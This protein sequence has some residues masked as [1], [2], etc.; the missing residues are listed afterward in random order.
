MGKGKWKEII[1]VGDLKENAPFSTAFG[2]I[3]ILIIKMEDKIYVYDGQCP[4]HGAPLKDGVFLNSVIICSRHTARFDALDG[5]AVSP[6]AIKDLTKYEV[7]IEDGKIYIRAPGRESVKKKEHGTKAHS[8]KEDTAFVI[9][10]AGP[11][12]TSAAVKLREEGYD[13]RLLMLTEDFYF[14]Y[15]RTTLSKG[16][17]SGETEKT[18]ILLNDEDVY[19]DLGIE[20]MRNH[21]V[22]DLNIKQKTVTLAHE[23]ELLYEKLLIATGG[24][25]RTPNIPGTD[26]AGLYLLR[27]LYDA[28]AL[29]A[30]LKTVESIIIIGAGFI[31]LEAAAAIKKRDIDVHIVAPESLPLARVFGAKVSR[32][33]QEEYE[34]NGIRFHLDAYPEEI[35]KGE[36]GCKL[37]LSDESSL[38]A[39]IILAG[40]GIVPSVVFLSGTDLVKNG[41][42]HVNE[43][44]ETA[45]G[46]VYG[47]G[48]AVIVS[49]ARTGKRRH[50]EH[51]IEASL[52]GQYA[53]RAMLGNRRAFREVP[54]FWTRMFNTE[55]QFAGYLG[56]VKNIV[57]RGNPNVDAF[58]AGY[59]RRGR[60]QAVAGC[61][62]EKEV[63][64]FSEI[65]KKGIPVKIAQFRDRETDLEELIQEKTK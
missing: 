23:T 18:D 22:I 39:D 54:F 2:K 28:E 29:S 65:I 41:T 5:K 42:L 49:D 14:P 11:A 21:K 20:I 27:S 13:G 57:F 9:I 30:A 44:F 8:V 4:H 62:R 45:A 40:I 12:G 51:W 19:R 24:I 32:L 53:A 47:A 55:I 38:Y 35:S 31:G 1:G 26:S 61:G 64:L 16:F 17:L 10:G 59:F 33:I 7:K 15:D 3:E 25:P 56:S 36:K 58:L 50:I 60:L 37:L 48:D 34:K 63:I 52:H 6:P 46:D 43:Y